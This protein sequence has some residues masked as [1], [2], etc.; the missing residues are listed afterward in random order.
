MNPV[1]PRVQAFFRGYTRA[2]LNEFGNEIDGLTR[3]ETFTIRAGDLS[4][5]PHEGYAD[6][7]FML[8]AKE[9]RDTVKARNPEIAFLASDCTGLSLPQDDGSTWR[10]TPAQNAVV[11]DGTYQDSQC[12]PTAWQYGLF[13]NYRNVL[14]SCNWRPVEHFEWTVLGVQAFGVPVAISNGW[15]ENKGIAR[16]S[17]SETE[18]LLRLFALRKGQRS[19]VRWIE[20]RE[21]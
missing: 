20:S 19:R 16:Y 3:D 15:G 10:A 12:Y 11:F 17:Q 9:L 14:W 6:R 7:E 13:P 4:R 18:Q 5:A 21:A 8:L 1:H 2:L